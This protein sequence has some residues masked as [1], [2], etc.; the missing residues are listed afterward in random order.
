MIFKTISNF[1]NKF[2]QTLNN[3]LFDYIIIIIFFMAFIH[4]YTNFYFL[5]LSTIKKKY[6]QSGIFNYSM[7]VFIIIVL[8][9]LSFVSLHKIITIQKHGAT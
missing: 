9:F 1:L 2:H 8:T 5:Y 4:H 3:V 6:L 7:N